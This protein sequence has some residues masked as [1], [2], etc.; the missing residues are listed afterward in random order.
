V[1]DCPGYSPG[2]RRRLLEFAAL[3]E[4]HIKQDIGCVDGT[5]V[6]GW[7]GNKRLRFYNARD[8]VMRESKFDPDLD[9]T[10]DFN[11]LPTLC[12]D[13]RVLRDGLRRYGTLRNEDSIDL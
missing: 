9:I 2:Y 11:G 5:I 4:M 3:C 7:H 12:R 8:Q 13:N 1:A 6:H 10:A